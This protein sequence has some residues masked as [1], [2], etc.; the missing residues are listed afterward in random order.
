LKPLGA[1]KFTEGAF[2]IAQLMFLKDNWFGENKSKMK[3][4]IGT[5]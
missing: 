3:N 1:E 2:L 5:N 4:D